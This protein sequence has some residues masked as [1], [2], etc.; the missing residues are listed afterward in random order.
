MA[1]GGILCES[2]GL[3]LCPLVVFSAPCKTGVCQNLW[4]DLE[5]S[6]LNFP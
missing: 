2:L 5:Q 6:M 3:Q 4:S 1:D